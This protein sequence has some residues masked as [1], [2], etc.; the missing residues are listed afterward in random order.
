MLRKVFGWIILASACYSTQVYAD[1]RGPGHYVDVSPNSSEGECANFSQ[2]YSLA[3][4]AIAPGHRIVRF[5]YALVGDN[6]PCG[7]WAECTQT[8]DSDVQKAVQFRMQGHS[9]E[10]G[11]FGRNNGVHQMQ[12]TFTYDVE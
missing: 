2:W 6:H 7:A 12:M 11:L 4:P 3:T 9:E 5:S 8:I 1:P 10:C